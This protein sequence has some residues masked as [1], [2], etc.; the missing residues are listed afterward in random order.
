MDTLQKRDTETFAWHVEVCTNPNH[1]HRSWTV[2][3]LVSLSFFLFSAVF[4][5]FQDSLIQALR[6]EKEKYPSHYWRVQGVHLRT[7]IC[8]NL[9]FS[10]VWSPI[11]MSR[12]DLRR[13]FCWKSRVEVHNN[14]ECRRHVWG[15]VPPVYATGQEACLPVPCHVLVGLTSQLEEKNADLESMGD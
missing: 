3:T 6:R 2:P 1:D 7:I 14:S 13:S 9:V 15:V 11:V 8:L 10:R 5:V 4:A 12:D